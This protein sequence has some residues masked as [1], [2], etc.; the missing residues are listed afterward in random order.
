MNN[1]LALAAVE[2]LKAGFAIT[3]NQGVVYSYDNRNKLPVE[4][5]DMKTCV[6]IQQ[7]VEEFKNSF[8][9]SQN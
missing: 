4:K 5:Y 9:S 2:L 8:N 7:T 1:N 3:S 6:R